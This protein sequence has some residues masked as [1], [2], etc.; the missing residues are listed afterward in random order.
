MAAMERARA[1]LNHLSLV[2]DRPKLAQ[3]DDLGDQVRIEL[4]RMNKIRSA[5][6]HPRRYMVGL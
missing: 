5:D 2:V 3:S 6:G 1:Y 4:G